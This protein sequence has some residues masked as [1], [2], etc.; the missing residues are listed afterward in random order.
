[1]AKAGGATMIAT[2]KTSSAAR[3]LRAED[4]RGTFLYG[5]SDLHYIKRRRSRQVRRYYPIGWSIGRSVPTRAKSVRSAVTL[6]DSPDTTGPR[7]GE[8]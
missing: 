7:A 8:R 2:A 5:E 4:K 1:M 6:G 3:V